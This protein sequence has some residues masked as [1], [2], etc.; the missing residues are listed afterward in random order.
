MDEQC[1]IANEPVEADPRQGE[2]LVDEQT[3]GHRA[4]AIGARLAPVGAR[5]LALAGFASLVLCEAPTRTVS[6]SFH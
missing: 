2:D 5:A 1:H 4:R 3:E 6:V